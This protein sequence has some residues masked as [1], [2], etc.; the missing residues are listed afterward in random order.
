MKK[1]FSLF[2]VSALL[3]MMLFSYGC[4]AGESD[5]PGTKKIVQASEESIKSYQASFD[6]QLEQL[7]QKEIEIDSIMVVLEE[8]N[9]QLSEKEKSLNERHVDLLK[10]QTELQSKEITAKMMMNT[11]YSLMI[12]GLILLLV[13]LLILRKLNKALYPKNE[14]D[15]EEE[16]DESDE[17]DSEEDEEKEKE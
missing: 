8:K 4:K 5:T 13:S 3:M 10:K 17:E 16:T 9:L 6:R 14:N 2:A 7:Q 1:V 15:E 11:G 12:I